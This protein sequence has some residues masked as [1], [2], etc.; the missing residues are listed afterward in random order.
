MNFFSEYSVAI[1]ESL[2]VC[3]KT[4]QTRTQHRLTEWLHRV[5]TL[6][7]EMSYTSDYTT[8]PKVNVENVFR[9]N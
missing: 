2:I 3:V 8:T 9:F 5:G 4:I 1:F 6:K 7:Y